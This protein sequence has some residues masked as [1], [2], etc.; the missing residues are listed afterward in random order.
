VLH[1]QHLTSI[2]LFRSAGGR[3]VFDL[4]RDQDAIPIGAG[5][6]TVWLAKGGTTINL[7]VEPQWTVAHEGAGP[8]RFQVFAGLTLQ[9]PIGR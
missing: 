9:F 1:T 5:I 6:G 2:D 4:A 3:G 7:F 8:P